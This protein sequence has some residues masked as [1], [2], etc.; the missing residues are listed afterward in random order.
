[1]LGLLAVRENIEP[2]GRGKETTDVG[3]AAATM[4]GERR[5]PLG[6]SK[7][8]RTVAV[9]FQPLPVKVYSRMRSES[10]AAN[11][12]SS[13]PTTFPGAVTEPPSPTP[14]SPVGLPKRR[15]PSE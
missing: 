5:R 11:A 9:S 4:L 10:S 7:G 2:V 3:V 12:R 6:A 8:D 14:K 13:S 1:M 15:V